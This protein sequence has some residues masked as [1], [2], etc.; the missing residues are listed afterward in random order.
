MSWSGR[1]PIFT[2][3]A[4]P[5]G[6][7][8][9]TMVQIVSED[10]TYTIMNYTWRNLL[11]KLR[12]NTIAIYCNSIYSIVYMGKVYFKKY[13]P[14]IYTYFYL[15]SYYILLLVQLVHTSTSLFCS[16]Y[17][18][19]LVWLVHTQYFNQCSYQYQYIRTS[20]KIVWVVH[21]S[22]STARKNFFY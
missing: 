19:L 2:A 7:S 15:Y 17:I 8:T 3:S 13:T 9:P 21:S 12:Y 14:Y 1:P 10:V 11:Y 20:T 18:L 4:R 5:L 22:T 6:L 16:Q